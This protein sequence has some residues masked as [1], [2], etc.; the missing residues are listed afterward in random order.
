MDFYANMVDKYLILTL[1]G[2]IFCIGFCG[3][4]MSSSFMK[5]FVSIELMIIP[6]VLNF[7]YTV[8]SN[9]ICFGSITCVIAVIISGSIL[10]LLSAVIVSGNISKTKY[11]DYKA[12]EKN[13]M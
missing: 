12:I 9:D 4:L 7:C 2:F 11:D 5:F 6:S 1:S 10:S 3:V 13:N 8:Q